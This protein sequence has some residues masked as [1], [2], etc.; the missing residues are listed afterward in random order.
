MNEIMN[1]RIYLDLMHKCYHDIMEEVVEIDFNKVLSTSKK[2]KL[3][4]NL[5]YK[6]KC[7]EIWAKHYDKFEK[8]VETIFGDDVP[9][10]FNPPHKCNAEA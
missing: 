9:E 1:I 5:L 6:E 10:Q 7:N 8:A 4:P 2:A 3:N